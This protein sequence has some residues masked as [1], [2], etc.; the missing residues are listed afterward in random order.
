MA[1]AVA[2][3]ASAAL[4][5]SPGVLVLLRHGQSISNLEKRFT[6][7]GNS[8]LTSYGREQARAAGRAMQAKGIHFDAVFTSALDRAEETARLALREMG[9]EKA[10]IVTDP[11]FNERFYGDIQG[12]KRDDL[13]GLHGDQQVERWRHD[14]FERPPGG[15]SIAETAGRVL[16][17]FERR[18]KPLLEAGQNVLISAHCDSLRPLMVAL[19]HVPMTDQCTFLE[20]A[21]PLVYHLDEH[22]EIVARD[23]LTLGSPPADRAL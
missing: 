23:V 1:S 10:A 13:A 12:M 22:L 18:V 2:G 3:V 19:E 9:H 6:G 14:Y 21:V 4:A 8:P 11:A 7:S 5:R 15:E 20:N 17:A 16:D